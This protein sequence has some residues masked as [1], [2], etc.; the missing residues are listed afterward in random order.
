MSETDD[1]QTEYERYDVWAH[2]ILNSVKVEELPTSG[3]KCFPEYLRGPYAY[4]ESVLKKQLN[5]EHKVLEIGAGLGKHTEDLVKSGAS[6]LATDISDHSL[7]VLQKRIKYQLNIDVQTKVAD[8]ENLPFE[9]NSFDYVVSAGS[10]SYG[11]NDIVRDEIYRVLKLGGNFICVDSLNHNPVYALNRWVHFLRG[12]RTNSTLQRMPK[13]SL[14]KKY[15]K[16]FGS[17]EAEFFGSIVWASPMLKIFGNRFAGKVIDRFDKILKT[18][19]SAF[20][21]VMCVKKVK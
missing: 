14:L 4:F 17:C 2:E 18:K 15:E 19:K 16:K 7:E 3:S 12:S 6:V 20:K 1:K 13:L 11:D 21:F 5:G 9:D 8:M 10:L